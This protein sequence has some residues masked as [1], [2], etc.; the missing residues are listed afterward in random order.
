MVV[1]PQCILD[2]FRCIHTCIY[3]CPP[4][5]KLPKE[6]FHAKCVLIV[7]VRMLLHKAR[8]Y[9]GG[10]PQREDEGLGRER[11]WVGGRG[12]VSIALHSF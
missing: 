2:V 8:P 6:R 11:L 10:P 1:R 12:D 3:S 9:M 4:M 5:I 7:S